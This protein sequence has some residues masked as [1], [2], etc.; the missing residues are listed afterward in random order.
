MVYITAK[1]D[2]ITHNKLDEISRCTNRIEATIDDALVVSY[3]PRSILR[4]LDY[5]SV[6]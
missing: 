6:A 5:N 3:R 1:F 4:H 2:R